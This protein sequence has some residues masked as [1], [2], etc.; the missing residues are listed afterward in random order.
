MANKID[1]KLILELLQTPMSQREIIKTRHISSKSITAVCRRAA[2]LG[3]SYADLADKSDDEVYLLFFPDKFQKETVYAPVNYEY[4]HG[5]LKKTGVTLKLL[6]QEYKDGVKVG[7]PVGYT[8]FRDDYAKYV[9]QNNLT[10]HIT[11]KPGVVCEVDWSGKTMRLH[12][13]DD[14]DKVYPVYL[15]VAALPYSQLAYVEPCLNMN[16]QTW[17]NCNVHMFEYFGGVTLR[18]VCDNLK[19]GVITHPR[20]GDIVLNQCYEDFSN[21]YCTAIMPA[22]VKKPKQKA[23]VE[24]TVGKIATAIIARLRNNEY[25]SIHELKTDVAAALED[26]NNKPFQKREG[27]RREVFEANERSTL[28]PLPAFPYEYAVWEYGRVIGSDFHVTYQTCKYS[29]PYRFVGKTVD[30]KITDSVIEIYCGHERISSHKRFPSYVRNKYDTYPEDI[31]ERFQKTEWNELSLRQWAASIGKQT[32][33][34]ID[35]IFKSYC[36]SEQGINPAMSVLKL[37]KKYSSERLETACE[38]ALEHV[39]VP[40]YSHLK[41]ILAAGQ[42]V[43][44][45]NSKKQE[46]E[47]SPAGFVRGAAYYGG[48]DHAE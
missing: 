4:V 12:D 28:R 16:E 24:G 11:H 35:R 36:M 9:E 20:E 19:T 47:S 7:V 21:H 48:D 31:P 40:R 32:L 18:I 29:V 6:W 42:D 34:V 30:L 3:V 5:E 46:N 44:Y 13:L 27:S 39:S 38:L 1:V 45:K 2:E 22:G 37:S 23:S 10:N 26:F 41:V 14:G 43:E 8:K 17:I 33:A 15:F 25:T